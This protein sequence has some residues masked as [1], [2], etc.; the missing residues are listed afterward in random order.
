MALRITPAAARF[1]VWRRAV[2]PGRRV[3]GRWVSRLRRRRHGT[4]SLPL[5]IAVTPSFEVEAGSHMAFPPHGVAAVDR[6]AAMAF[7][8]LQRRC[9]KAHALGACDRRSAAA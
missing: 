8:A 4:P 1:G 7:C 5:T 9:K 3:A 6:A 2:R